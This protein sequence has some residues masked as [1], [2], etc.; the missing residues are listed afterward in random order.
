MVDISYKI[1][2]TGTDQE[3]DEEEDEVIVVPHEGLD[4]I[5]TEK[6]S[7]EEEKKEEGKVDSEG[8]V[9]KRF[10]AQKQ[11]DFSKNIM[12]FKDFLKKFGPLAV[13]ALI[14]LCIF[15]VTYLCNKCCSADSDDPFSQQISKNI[16]TASSRR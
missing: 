16:A 1:I 11:K 2:E 10:R 14:G 3:V 12:K 5:E 15:S 6:P 13:I 7:V 9:A 4:G 8:R